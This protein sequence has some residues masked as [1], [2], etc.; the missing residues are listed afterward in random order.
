MEFQ[1]DLGMDGGF[2]WRA[3]DA[4]GNELAASAPLATRQACVR[5]IL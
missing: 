2:V 3:L 5:A 4:D 1:I